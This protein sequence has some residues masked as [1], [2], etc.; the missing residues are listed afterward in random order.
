[1]IT[2]IIFPNPDSNLNYKFKIK[3]FEGISELLT[4][5]DKNLEEITMIFKENDV[6]LQSEYIYLKEFAKINDNGNIFRLIHIFSNKD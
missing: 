2:E 1:M 6:Y 3:K 5:D 4:E